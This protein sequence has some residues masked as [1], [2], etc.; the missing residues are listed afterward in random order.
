[1]QCLGLSSHWHGDGKDVLKILKELHNAQSFLP[2]V[3]ISTFIKPFHIVIF[4]TFYSVDRRATISELLIQFYKNG[5][6]DHILV[7]AVTYLD[8]Y[9]IDFSGIPSIYALAKD[10]AVSFPRIEWLSLWFE[11]QCEIVSFLFTI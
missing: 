3:F 9:L 6:E 10:I 2:I 7:D 8:F 1:M 11:R 4:P 5:Q